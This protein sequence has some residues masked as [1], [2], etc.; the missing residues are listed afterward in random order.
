[1]K[2]LTLAATL[3][4]FVLLA[5]CQN[6]TEEAATAL[7]LDTTQQQFSYG[8]AYNM[9]QRM[10]AENLE[11]DAAAFA[12]GI[13]D[14][15]S[16]VDSQLSDEQVQAAMQAFQE[17]MQAKQMAAAEEVAAANAAEAAE[18][19]ASNA[20]REGVMQTESGLQYEVVTQGDGEKPV[21]ADTV[22]VHYRGTLL[23]GTEFDSSYSRGEPVKF[24]LS[25]VI[26][27]WT[28]GLQLMPAGSKYTLYIPA[29]LAYGAGGAGNLIGPNA[30]LKFEVELLSIEKAED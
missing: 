29:E 3:S 26:A 9:G 8:M 6:N 15:L 5:A 18:F 20:Q 19:F 23:D 27:G 2:K 25:Q 30:A 24:G 17:E 16:G 22:E 10:Q 14:A 7:A 11:V 21:A 4:S 1:M 13:S 28:E 12:A